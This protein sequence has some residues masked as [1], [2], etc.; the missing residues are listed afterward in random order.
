MKWVVAR[1]LAPGAGDAR[2][3]VD[4]DV[5]D[6]A[7]ARQRGEPEQRGGRV[8]AGVGDEVG[9]HDRLAVELGQP[10]DGLAEQLGRAVAAVPVLVDRAVAQAEVGREVDHAHAALAQRG[11]RRG[12]HA[13]RPADERGVDLAL[14]GG[15]VVLEQQR[16][17]RARVDRLEHRAGLR[18]RGH[19]AQLEVRVPVH[20]RGG[21]RAGVAGRAEDGDVS[22][23]AALRAARP[24]RRRSS[25][26][27]CRPPRRSACGR[28][29]GTRAAA[30][31]TAEPSPTCAPR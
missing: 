15:V 10:V 25:R 19:V 30:P 26:A 7:G 2:L 23:A 4:H 13:V 24:A 8:A 31:A 29:R 9:A 18:A 1:R 21:D 27:A 17:A 14:D 28:A 12:R 16:H 5:G 3:R 11:D 6:H 20:E 22:H